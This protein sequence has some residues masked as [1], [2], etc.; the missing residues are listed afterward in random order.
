[1][2]SSVNPPPNTMHS[3]LYLAVYRVLQNLCNS[4]ASW[5]V[6]LPNKVA[7]GKYPF[8]YTATHTLYLSALLECAH[9]HTYVLIYIIY[10]RATSLPRGSR[11]VLEMEQN[12]WNPGM[13]W[14]SPLLYQ[15][16]AAAPAHYHL[17][18]L[19]HFEGTSIC[20]RFPPPQHTTGVGGNSNRTQQTSLYERGSGSDSEDDS[21]SYNYL[22]TRKRRVITSWE[23]GMVCQKH[24]K[25]PLCWEKCFA[26]PFLMIFSLLLNFR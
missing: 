10:M 24:S 18:N 22:V 2:A 26:K 5:F 1:M 25:P 21:G 14:P 9:A 11:F 6:W 7:T 23:C 15:Q 16:S 17:H 12:A 13:P 20:P 4:Q 8:V 3:Y 19:Q